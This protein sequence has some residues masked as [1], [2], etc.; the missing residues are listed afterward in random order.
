VL[1]AD[2]AVLA[3]AEGQDI[4][5]PRAFGHVVGPGRLDPL[6]RVARE[7]AVAH[8]STALEG[9]MESGTA[10]LVACPDDHPGTGESRPTMQ[11]LHLSPNLETWLWQLTLP[12][13]KE[14]KNMI[15]NGKVKLDPLDSRREEGSELT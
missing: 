7:K 14:R 13:C 10:M 8:R 5:V 11:S 4:V 12:F 2:D 15:S 1:A 3:P 9:L 6:V